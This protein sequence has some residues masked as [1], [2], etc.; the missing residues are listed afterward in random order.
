MNTKNQSSKRKAKALPIEENAQASM[1]V[2]EVTS[3]QKL[4]RRKQKKVESTRVEGDCLTG[5]TV[6]ELSVKTEEIVGMRISSSFNIS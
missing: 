2:S 1:V 3:K 5:T 4:S 6:E